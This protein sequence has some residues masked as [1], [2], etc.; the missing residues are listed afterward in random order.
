MFVPVPGYEG[1]YE[2]SDEGEVRSLARR[3]PCS[4]GTKLLKE[5][6]LKP[7]LTDDGYHVVTLY[8]NGSHETLRVHRIVLL[9]F[10]GPCPQGMET[11]HGDG[12]RTVNRL[13]NLKWGT[14]EDNWIDRK[15]HGRIGR[16]PRKETPSCFM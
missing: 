1:I 15:R 8:K 6:I 3:V 14:P 13:A 5:R 12:S 4:G 7:S 9:A 11:C 16:T 10:V 2:V